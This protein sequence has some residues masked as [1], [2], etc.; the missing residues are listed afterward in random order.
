MRALPLFAALALLLASACAPVPREGEEIHT[1]QLPEGETRLTLTEPI[2]VP[3]GSSRVWIQ[4]GLVATGRDSYRPSC[5][6]RL[7]EGVESPHT[8]EPDTF[9][10]VEIRRRDEWVRDTAPASVLLASA[11]RDTPRA[12]QLTM[13]IQ[14]GNGG[15]GW[16]VW[17]TDFRLESQGQPEVDRLSCAVWVPVSQMRP[18]TLADMRRALGELL[19]VEAPE[20]S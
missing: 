3:A 8:I 13:G 14:D 17:R 16:R 11:G 2:T 7:Q 1:Y 6:L 4:D 12:R 9:T 15:P 20:G 18:F 5:Q 10:A 19:V